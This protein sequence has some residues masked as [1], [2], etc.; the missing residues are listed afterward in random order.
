MGA[1]GEEGGRARRIWWTD[2]AGGRTSNFV[3]SQ[4][5][6]APNASRGVPSDRFRR[7]KCKIENRSCENDPAPGERG[8]GQDG[9]SGAFAGILLLGIVSRC[10][11]ITRKPDPYRSSAN[12]LKDLHRAINGISLMPTCRSVKE[13]EN[14]HSWGFAS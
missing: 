4:S 13:R 5:Y 8:A 7:V 2:G 1:R 12:V 14:P 3:V 11:D 6:A 10:L 9:R